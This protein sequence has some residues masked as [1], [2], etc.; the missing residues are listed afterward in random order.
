MS[1][2][3]RNAIVTPIW[4]SL[5]RYLCP[6]TH[7]FLFAADTIILLIHI[8]FDVS[9][10]KSTNLLVSTKNYEILLYLQIACQARK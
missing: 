10:V 8:L 4:I 7:F 3:D 1:E 2:H 6:P 9:S 5:Y